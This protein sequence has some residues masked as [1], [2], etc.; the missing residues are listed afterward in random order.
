MSSSAPKPNR[1][2]AVCSPEEALYLTEQGWTLAELAAHFRV[3]KEW[4][5]RLILRGRQQARTI[6]RGV[7]C[8]GL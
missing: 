2:K 6:S 8:L 4:I 3:R 7:S 1:C 5:G